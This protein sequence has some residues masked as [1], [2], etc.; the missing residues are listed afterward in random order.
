MNFISTKAALQPPVY[1]LINIW[2]AAF[3]NGLII[4]FLKI[5]KKNILRF[6]INFGLTIKPEISLVE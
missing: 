5:Y 4:I 3:L 2:T 6:K 1:L